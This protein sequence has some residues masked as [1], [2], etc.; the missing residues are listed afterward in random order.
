MLPAFGMLF[1]VVVSL[2]ST[3]LHNGAFLNRMLCELGWWDYLDEWD[4]RI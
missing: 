2:T 1:N 4:E 3:T